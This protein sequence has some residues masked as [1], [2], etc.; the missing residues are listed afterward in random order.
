MENLASKRHTFHETNTGP[1]IEVLLWSPLHEIA[2]ALKDH[3][4]QILEFFVAH[5][6]DQ[7]LLSAQSVDVTR[8]YC[9]VA[10]WKIVETNNE[11]ISIPCPTGPH[12]VKS[13]IALE[14]CSIAFANWCWWMMNLFQ[15]SDWSRTTISIILWLLLWLSGFTSPTRP[16]QL[17]RTFDEGQARNTRLTLSGWLYLNRVDSSV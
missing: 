9:L 7:G 3:P 5:I 16:S 1:L 13:L 10:G 17:S 4:R 15:A 11:W 8:L 12:P 6:L 2:V 14:K